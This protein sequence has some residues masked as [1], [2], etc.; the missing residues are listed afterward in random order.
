MAN[1]KGMDAVGYQCPR[2]GGLD[3]EVLKDEVDIGVGI[4]TRVYGGVCKKCGGII[5]CETC[6]GWDGRHE[7]W[8]ELVLPRS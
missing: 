3:F 2:C 5:L 6:G 4:Q 7:V 8:C 1:V